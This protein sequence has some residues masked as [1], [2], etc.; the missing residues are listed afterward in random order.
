[1]LRLPSGEPKSPGEKKRHSRGSGNPG[2]NSMDL[3]IP[4]KVTIV[5]EGNTLDHFFQELSGEEWLAWQRKIAA[6]EGEND[7]D[8]SRRLILLAYDARVCAV[9]GYTFEGKP[10][11]EARP[12]NWREYI[13]GGHKYLAWIELV[14]GNNLKKN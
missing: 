3:S 4:R 10:L 11:E 8:R 6:G 9:A 7:D 1:M 5:V 13:P 14:N 2:G 12:D